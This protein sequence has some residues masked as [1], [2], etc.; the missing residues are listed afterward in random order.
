MKT[1]YT[2]CVV[3]LLSNLLVGQ[4]YTWTQVL[5]GNSLG[6]PIVVDKNN[7][8]IV[9]YGSYDRIYK[10]W[11]R[12]NSFTSIG[13]AISGSSRIKNIIVHPEDSLLIFVATEGTVQKTVKST[14][15][16]LTWI[17]TGNW[18][19]S[20]FGIPTTQDP[21]H[22]DTIYTMSGNQF[23]IS[24]DFGSTWSVL[25][26]VSGFGT[27]C[28]IEVFPDS[29]NIILIGDNGTGIFRSSNY[30]VTW[31]QVFSTGGEIPTI[32]M[33]KN[34]SGIAWATRW[35][36]GGGFLKTLDYGLTWQLIPYFNGLNMWGVDV[37][38]ED[39][40]FVVTGQYS[41]NKIYISKDFGQSWIP[42]TIAGANY[43]IYVVDSLTVFAAQSTGFY[44]LQTPTVVTS[45]PVKLIFSMDIRKALDFHT[46]ER[47]DSIVNSVW[48]KGGL[49]LLGG[50]LGNWTYSDTLNGR[51]KKMYDNGEGADS[52]AGDNVWTYEVTIPSGTPVTSFSYR[53]GIS[54]PGIENLQSQF[55]DFL[56]NETSPTLSRMA[57]LTDSDSVITIDNK[58]LLLATPKAEINP[59]SIA[60]TGTVGDSLNFNLEIGNTLGKDDLLFSLSIYSDSILTETYGLQS[61]MFIDSTDRSNKYFVTKPV[62]LTEIHQYF[63]IPKTTE[64][65]FFVYESDSSRGNYNILYSSRVTLN[66]GTGFMSSGP[67]NVSLKANKYYVIGASWTNSLS[68]YRGGSVPLNTSFGT[69][70]SGQTA[71][72][73]YPPTDVASFRSANLP[74]YLQKLSVTNP[75]EWINFASNE[76]I[77]S[78]GTSKI[79]N[80]NM[81]TDSL[82]PGRYDAN[83]MI[84]TNDTAM[85][86]KTI[87]LS[88]RLREIILSSD[89]NTQLP[90]EFSLFQNYPNPFNPNTIISY[91]IS[92]ES[93]VKLII[94]NSL[95]EVIENIS[96]YHGKPGNY[97]FEWNPREMSSGVYF[98]RIVANSENGEK[99]FDQTKK[100]LL[101]R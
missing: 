89:D 78:P 55:P 72:A 32:S 1:I 82:Q 2:I 80:F 18:S 97:V 33:Q 14:D 48:L 66:S 38:P 84:G 4:S 35:G 43:A 19:F 57:L 51:L 16:G 3:I 83:L 96:A 26:T 23:L 70:I 68:F 46:Q 21:Q 15:G 86:V 20:Y 61:N 73:S 5:T 28:D 98:Y 13:N 27:P 41:G 64:V 9:Y 42:T 30:G 79:I 100:M 92:K 85:S 63:E 58:W 90:K 65:Y 49:S 77:V 99:Y 81:L 34:S 6:N 71:G 12:G 67:I 40:N 10:S 29:S 31:Q 47:I 8:N 11:D 54:Y 17:T 69:L 60:L 101:I 36:G 88:L 24:P 52:I 94:Y 87:P 56:N 75:I 50:N 25:A 7:S 62:T 44:K 37:S 39:S 53:F 45:R 95:G 59:H 76:G 22:P 93:I 74:I 91:N